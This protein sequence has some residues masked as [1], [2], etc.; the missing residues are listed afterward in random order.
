MILAYEKYLIETAKVFGANASV[1]AED[2]KALVDLQVEIAKV[3]RPGSGVL[4]SMLLVME[5]GRESE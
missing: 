1:A 4:Y 2:V 3:S 5:R